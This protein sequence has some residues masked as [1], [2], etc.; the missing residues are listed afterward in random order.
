MPVVREA[1]QEEVPAILR[2]WS[3]AYVTLSFTDDAEQIERLFESDRA[4]MLVAHEADDLVGTLIAAWDGWRGNMYRLAVHP[5]HRGG[6]IAR[7]LV[8]AGE[9]LLRERGARRI[10]ALVTAQDAGATTFWRRAGYRVDEDT[11]RYFKNLP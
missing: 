2:L 4:S 11:A 3:E 6:G 1:R 5:D 7:A 9:R 8:E 10:T